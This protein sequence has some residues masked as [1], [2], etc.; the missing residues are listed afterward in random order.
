CLDHPPLHLFPTRR[1]SDLL[2]PVVSAIGH[3][4]DSPLL[5]LVADVRCSTP[6]DAGKRVVPDVA[7]QQSLLE[8]WVRRMRHNVRNFLNVE[9][10]DRKS[11]RL[12]PVTWPARMP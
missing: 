8:T 7:E 11:T 12:T 4:P 10:R 1:S 9:E 2:T 6:T 3:E 5:D